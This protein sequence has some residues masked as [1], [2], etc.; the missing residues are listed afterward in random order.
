[1]KRDEFLGMVALGEDGM[2]QFKADVRNGDSLASEMAAFAN[3]EEAPTEGEFEWSSVGKQLRKK[4]L[5]NCQP[6]CN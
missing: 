5:V 1:M 6:G 3:S 4:S 2:R